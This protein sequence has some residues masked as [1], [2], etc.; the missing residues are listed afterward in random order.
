MCDWGTY[1]ILC[2][3]GE[4]SD[5]AFDFLVP[6]D[7]RINIS[8]PRLLSQIDRIL[9]QRLILLLGILRVD[10]RTPRSL[11]YRRFP[12]LGRDPRLLQRLFQYRILGKRSDNVVLRNVRVLLAFLDG[13]GGAEEFEGCGGEGKLFRGW[14]LGGQA[15]ELAADAALELLQVAGGLG[16]DGS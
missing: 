11:L 12:R 8:F 16:E 7:N 13:L 5:C 4:D 14:F 9:C 10:T 2:S 1:V 3:A 15:D 6:A